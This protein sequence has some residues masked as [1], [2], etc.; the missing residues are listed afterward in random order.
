MHI[1]TL[2]LKSLLAACLL[3][4][5]APAAFAQHAEI[6]ITDGGIINTSA[7]GEN[8]PFEGTAF[9]HQFTFKA[10]LLFP[11]HV[12]AGLFYE[13]AYFSR[14]ETL[15]VNTGQRVVTYAIAEPQRTIGLEIYT[16]AILGAFSYLRF[17]ALFG[18]AI[19][20]TPDPTRLSGFT[21][22]RDFSYS[23]GFDVSY[24]FP[25]TGLLS[26]VLNTGIRYSKANYGPA[27]SGAFIST[28]SFPLTAGLSYE[29]N[30]YRP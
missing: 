3:C 24:G 14:K 8:A 11:G 7:I 5:G 10:G 4:I 9:D 27:N 21:L 25:I 28:Y 6:S 12:G 15:N 1:A 19:A 22:S 20:R 18:Y 13:Q 23:T 2:S 16:K 26:G 29:F 30:H 17:G